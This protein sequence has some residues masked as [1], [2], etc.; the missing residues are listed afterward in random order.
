VTTHSRPLPTTNSDPHSSKHVFNPNPHK[1]SPS[2]SQPFLARTHCTFSWLHN[3]AQRQ[4]YT[5]RRYTERYNGSQPPHTVVPA[6][7]LY[8]PPFTAH[9]PMH[10]NITANHCITSS[11]RNSPRSSLPSFDPLR[12]YSTVQCVPIVPSCTLPVSAYRTNTSNCT[13]QLV[14]S[15]SPRTPH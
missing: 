3:T 14:L 10:S 4:P 6:D 11:C 13:Q 2:P 9:H 8:M 15:H 12:P 1:A 5:A 7:K